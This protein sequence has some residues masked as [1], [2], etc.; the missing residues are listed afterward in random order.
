[1]VNRKLRVSML[2]PLALLGAVGVAAWW[3]GTGSSPLGAV[4]SWGGSTAP[5]AEPSPAPEAALHDPAGPMPP[6]FKATTLDGKPIA[7]A[8]HKG[9]V[10]L[11]DFWATW[12]APCRA[13]IPHVKKAYEKF[14]A[15]GFEVIGISLDESRDALKKFIA[16]EKMPWPQIVNMDV[17]GGK[18]PATLYRVEAIPHTVLVGRDGSIAA[19]NLRG[20]QLLKEVEQALKAPPPNAARDEGSGANAAAPVPVALDIGRPRGPEHAG[21]GVLDQPAPAW[22][23]DRWF[24]LPTGKSSLDIADYRGKVV[25]LYGFQSWCP[26]CHAHGFPTLQRLVEKFQNADDVA[27]VAVQT[28]FEGFGT[29]TPDAARTTAERYKLTIPVGHSGREGERSGLMRAYKTGGT[30]WTVIIDKEG[31]VRF[32]DFHITPEQGEQVI[33]ALRGSPAVEKPAE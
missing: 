14:H 6:A 9:K 5:A 2:A 20:E 11:I 32:N 3:A 23:V 16:R 15:R 31:V 33:T 8:D 27:F 25:Y 12:C 19:M 26:G 30:P 28:A 7:L 4:L 10:V 21:L 17:E 29:N 13:E 22:E 1:M 18:D 24:N